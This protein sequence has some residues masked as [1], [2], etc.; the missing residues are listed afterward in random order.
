M[1]LSNTIMDDILQTRTLPYNLRSNTDFAR[2]SVNTSRF[3]LNS[4]RYFASKVWNIVPSDIKNASNLNIFKNKI[5]KWKPK[6]YHC[7]LC[8]PYVNNLGFVNLV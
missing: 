1:N 8:Q 4:L 2:I 6:E 3:G 5:R 7:Y